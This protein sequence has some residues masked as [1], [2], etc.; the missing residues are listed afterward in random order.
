MGLHN[1][2]ISEPRGTV[3]MNRHEVEIQFRQAPEEAA[4]MC[5]YDEDESAFKKGYRSSARWA[6][7]A[8][9]A[10]VM[11]APSVRRHAFKTSRL[12]DVE[13]LDLES[14]NVLS[15][16]SRRARTLS[17]FAQ[18]T[19]RRQGAAGYGHRPET[20]GR[21]SKATGWNGHLPAPPRSY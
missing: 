6:N 3:G 14:E 12:A 15:A 1:F 16:K 9:G 13:A 7:L 4:P 19:D 18:M 8:E 17:L 2:Q 20:A 10:R 11:T 21:V 5:D